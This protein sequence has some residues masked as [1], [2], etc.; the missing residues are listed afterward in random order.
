[1]KVISR[2]D[3]KNIGAK[4]YFTGNPCPKGH[5]CERFVSNTDCVEC[6]AVHVKKRSARLKAETV[7]KREKLGIGRKERQKAYYAR[8]K[9]QNKD[10]IEAAQRR[11]YETNRQEIIMRARKW[12]AAHPA[13]MNAQRMKRISAQLRRT[14]KW[15]DHEKIKEI[16][17]EAAAMRQILGI[18]VHVDHVIPLRGRTVSGLHVHEN[19]QVIPAKENS[20]KSNRFFGEL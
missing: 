1:M 7:A 2:L 20:L 9:A 19:L 3:A 11:H 18:K 10:K 5:I 12:G 15:A 13:M 8:W 14:P 17:R 4:R 16:Y 6:I